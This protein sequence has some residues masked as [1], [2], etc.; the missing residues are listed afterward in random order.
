MRIKDLPSLNQKGWIPGPGEEEECFFK[1]V[2]ALCQFAAY[3]PKEVDQFVT[4]GDFVAP[5]SRVKNLFDCTPNWVVAY[6]SDKNLSF[7][8]GG[9]TWTIEKNSLRVPLIQLKKT[10][11]REKLFKI[12]HREELLAH[13]L[14]HAVRM[15]FDEPLFEEIFAYQTSKRSYRRL[16]GPLFQKEWEAYAFIIT[17]CIPIGWESLLFF[18]QGLLSCSLCSLIPAL[19]FSFLLARLL[20]LRG[21]LGLAL[22]RIKKRLI[23]PKKALAA[24]LRMTDREIF[25]FALSRGQ[26]LDHFFKKRKSLR[27]QLLGKIYFKK[28]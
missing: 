4:D 27:H 22:F 21:I 14:V 28:S 15:Q 11:D 16:L 1:R 13:E 12:Y 24:A 9:A 2:E 10:L 6:Y 20:F 25:L 5:L 8:Q 19:F 18:Y 17:L 23:D 3:P 7:F 26:V